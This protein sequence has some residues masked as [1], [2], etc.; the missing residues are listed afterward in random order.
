MDEKFLENLL[1][2]AKKITQAERGM[3]VNNTLDVLKSINLEQAVMQSSDFSELANRCLRQAMDG[4]EAI[5]T[6]NIITDPSEAPTTNT[7]FADLRVVVAFPIGIIGAVYLDKPI[8]DG[9]IP[10]KTT[11]K[12]MRLVEHA[13]LQDQQEHSDE[14]LMALYEQID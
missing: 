10:K 9:V 6:N 13:L 2:A 3:V 8:R 14:E 7:N 11:E 4:G 12:L 5:I 1:F